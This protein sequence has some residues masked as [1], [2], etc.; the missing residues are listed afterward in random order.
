MAMRLQCPAWWVGGFALL[1]SAVGAAGQGTF[2]NLDFE[3]STIVSSHPSGYGYDTGIADVPGWT[4]YNGWGDS[5]YSDGMTVIYNTHTLDSPNVSLLGTGLPIPPMQGQYGVLLWGGDIIGSTNGAS[6]GQTGQIPPTAKSM[7]F[8]WSLGFGGVAYYSLQVTFAGHS[9]SFRPISSTASY[10]TYGADITA[11]A[12]QTGEIQFTTS[13]FGG[14]NL[15]DNIQFSDQPVPE[16][17]VSSLSAL[18][19]L[20]MGWRLLY[21][22]RGQRN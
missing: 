15:I 22:R 7:T 14:G 3:Q 4:E 5:N 21:R 19:A 12:G 8:M 9:L 10:E 1:L 2:Q 17:S 18:G 11:L 16:P 20:L 6:I 13:P